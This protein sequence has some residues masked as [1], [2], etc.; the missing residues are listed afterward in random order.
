MTKD[1]VP[2]DRRL[3][4][5]T[6]ELKVKKNG[7]FEA[8]LVAQGFGQIPSIDFTDNFLPVIYET[9]FR[10]ILVLLATYN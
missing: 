8:K 7:I 1:P 9:T 4:G 3:P 5:T 2:A 10:I 6:W